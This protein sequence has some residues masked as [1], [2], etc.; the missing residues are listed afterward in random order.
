LPTNVIGS[1]AMMKTLFSFILLHLCS[2]VGSALDLILRREPANGNVLRLT[3]R[4]L[5]SAPGC[6]IN[7][8]RINVII[9]VDVP[10]RVV[11]YRVNNTYPPSY[12]Y[13]REEIED[14]REPVPGYTSVYISSYEDNPGICYISGSFRS[15]GSR[16]LQAAIRTGAN[17]TYWADFALSQNFVEPEDEPPIISDTQIENEDNGKELDIMILYTP[18]VLCLEARLP[19]NCNPNVPLR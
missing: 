9:D 7:N 3:V 16:N 12:W 18:E 2:T 14:G 11:T 8:G 13:G 15:T 10:E 6:I 17:G 5:S 19:R 4:G 1:L